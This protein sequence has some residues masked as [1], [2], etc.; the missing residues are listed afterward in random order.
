MDSVSLTESHIL[1][2]PMAW[3]VHSR[4]DFPVYAHLF[5]CTI[6]RFSI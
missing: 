6:Q 3:V 1:E 2:S 4:A 5:H